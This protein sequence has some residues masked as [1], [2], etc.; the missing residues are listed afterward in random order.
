[1]NILTFDIEEWYIEKILGGGREIKFKEFD[2][3]LETILDNLE[4]HNTH[5]TFF[6]LGK[7][8]EEFPN[9]IKK[10]A[11]RGHEIGCHSHIHSW[12]NKMSQ[13]QFKE[14]TIKAISLLEDLTGEKIVSYRA[15]AFSICENNKWAFEV[16]ANAGIKNDASVFP[17][18]RDFGGFP[19]F[20]Q[21]TPVIVNYKDC[22]LN[23]F[24]IPLKKLPALPKKIAFSGGGYF[25]ILPYWFIR[26]CM[27]KSDYNMCYFH[28][29]DLLVDKTP[30][31]TRSE[32]ESYFNEPGSLKSRYSRYFKAN[33]GRKTA[34]KNLNKLIKDFNFISIE[35]FN[36][37]FSIN[38][39]IS[40]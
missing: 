26:D 10:I 28:I 40:L 7:I 18:G 9:V 4:N 25:R 20:T 27:K 17:G 15:P 13:E 37:D 33:I 2:F 29:E 30:L 35:E 1:M 21:Q 34:L 32:Y 3:I 19:S 22:R 23:E 38:K 16:L 36:R 31:M 5:A 24:P 8:A 12:I 14:D 6:C 11:S 39:T